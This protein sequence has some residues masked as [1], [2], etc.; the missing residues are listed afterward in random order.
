MRNKQMMRIVHFVE[1]MKRKRYPNAER[2]AK[3]LAELDLAENQPL[4]AG[5]KTVQRDIM[6]LRNQMQAPLAYCPTH[7]GYYLADPDWTLPSLSLSRGE[8]FTALFC[9]RVSEPFLPAPVQQELDE[10]QSI[11]LAAGEPGG[12]NLG[13]L[14]S[15]VVAT[16]ATVPL[17]PPLAATILQGWKEGRTLRVTYSRGSD[18]QVCERELDIHALFLAAGAWYARAYCH[19]RQGMRSFALHRIGAATLLDRRFERS[20]AVVEEVKRG[21]VFNYGFHQGIRVRVAASRARYFQ[22]RTW[23]PGQAVRPLADG[24]LEVTYPA[25]PEPLFLQWALSFTGAVTVL[26]PA[27]AREAV[28][29]AAASLLAV[30][31]A[32]GE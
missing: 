6:F 11:Q 27:A 18:D 5:A 15:V 13:I 1:E 2:F 31:A 3:R 21:R 10:V 26:E 12:I 8:L 32:A 30:H 25:V 4:A 20:A 24:A 19:L 28:R 14:E 22:E 29:A 7:K 23:F 17:D 16:G 9:N